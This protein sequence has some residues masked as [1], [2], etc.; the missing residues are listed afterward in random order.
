M[1]RRKKMKD[2]SVRLAVAYL[3]LA[4]AFALP[5]AAQSI[6]TAL[7]NAKIITLD[8]R[9]TIAEAL[10][11]RDGKI[12]AVGRSADIRGLAG[13]ATRTVDLGGRTVIPG[14]IDSH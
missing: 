10:A 4:G 14:L 1:V 13:P 5:A 11:V 12:V 2:R 3:V 9:S 8:E 7:V 6:D